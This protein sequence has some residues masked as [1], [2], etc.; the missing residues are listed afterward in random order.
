MTTQ[1]KLEFEIVSLY[2]L[3]GQF[4]GY[5]IKKINSPHLQSTNIWSDSAEEEDDIGDTVRRLNEKTLI[6]Q[7]WPTPNDLEVANLTKD[8]DWEP[9]EMMEAE[10]I[11]LEKSILVHP[12][13][14]ALDEN[15]FPILDGSNNFVLGD[16]VDENVI[17]WDNSKIVYKK[18]LAP[19][20]TA[21]QQRLFKAMEIVA[22]KRAGLG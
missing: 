7:Y 14:P 20:P 5:T 2:S 13:V 17:D 10:Q 18:G 11:D 22:R 1:V 4:R 3:D 8:P 19:D 9:L 12:R 15:G 6:T 21:A 16:Q